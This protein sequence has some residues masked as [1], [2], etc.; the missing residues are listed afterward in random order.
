MHRATSNIRLRPSLPAFGL[1]ALWLAVAMVLPVQQA[2]ATPAYAVQ[3]ANACNTCHVEPV[4]WANPER[5]LDR[6]CTLDCQGCHISPTGGGMRTPMGQFYA[7]ETLAMFGRRPSDAADP[8][9]FHDGQA[10]TEGSYR[11]F[12]GFEGWWPGEVEFRTIDDRLGDIDPDPTWQI[13]GDYR[14]MSVYPVD[15]SGRDIV[16]FPMQIDTY[17]AVHPLPNLTAYLDLGLQGSTQ[18]SFDDLNGPDDADTKFLRDVLW[19]RELYVMLHDLPG[20]AYVRGGRIPLPFG[21]RLPDHT[22]FTRDDL[23]DQYRHAYGVEAGWAPN[24]YWTNVALTYQGVD[25]WPGEVD[26]RH[27]GGVT[28]QGGLKQLGYTVGASAHIFAGEDDYREYM[29]GPMW[30][31]NLSPFVYL[32]EFDIRREEGVDLDETADTTDVGGRTSLYAV[33]ELQWFAIRGLIPRLRYEWTDRN[34]L[35]QEDHRH[36]FSMGVQW[37]ILWAL[38]VDLQWRQE[39]RPATDGRDNSELLLQVHGSF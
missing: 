11:L 36:R 37:D 28:L 15:N 30:A 22:I 8:M 33:H 2:V 16:A 38:Q 10:P 6:R 29:W 20:G 35:Y 27:G 26:L 25:N 17:L 7:R 21:W 19:L 13:G 24:E 18:R 12:R 23:F 5:V 9:R 4:G 31:L 39:F 32:G 1:G 34:V 14:T 3:A